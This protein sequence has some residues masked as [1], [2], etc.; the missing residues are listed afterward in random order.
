MCRKKMEL[1]ELRVCVGFKFTSRVYTV[2]LVC[3]HVCV[4][5][6]SFRFAEVPA[7]S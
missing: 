3:V 4:Y 1:N 5:F 6:Q 7:P 2:C